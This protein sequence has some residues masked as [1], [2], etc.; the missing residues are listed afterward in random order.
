ML[1]KCTLLWREAH[2]Q[3]E[4]HKSPHVPATF[5]GSDFEKV[6]AAVA[7]STFPSQNAQNTT[8]CINR[9]MGG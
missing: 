9:K 3:V 6:G 7:R 4:T 5:G 2:F 8:C 1:K